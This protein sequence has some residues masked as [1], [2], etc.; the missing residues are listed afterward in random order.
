MN[1]GAIGAMFGSEPSGVSETLQASPFCNV[2]NRCYWLRES[3][4]MQPVMQ[5]DALQG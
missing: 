5:E 3:L 1:G 4:G 2:P